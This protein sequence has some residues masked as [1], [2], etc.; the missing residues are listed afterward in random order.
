MMKLNGTTYL[1]YAEVSAV[2]D[3]ELRRFSTSQHAILPQDISYI[4]AFLYAPAPAPAPAATTATRRGHTRGWV[5]VRTPC[6]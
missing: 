3:G 4:D 2:I 6:A 5:C 1:T